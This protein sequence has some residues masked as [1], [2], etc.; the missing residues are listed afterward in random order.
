[1]TE[2]SLGSGPARHEKCRCQALHDIAAL[3]ARLCFDSDRAAIWLR[4]RYLS[5]LPVHGEDVAGACRAGPF[6]AASEADQSTRQRNTTVHQE[7]HG[8]GR[9]VPAAGDEPL[10]ERRFCSLLIEM[11][12]FRAALPI[13]G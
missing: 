11:E 8:D 13:D 6:E 9:R 7:T 2:L 1:M 4:R 12:G 10:E 5:Y 3:V